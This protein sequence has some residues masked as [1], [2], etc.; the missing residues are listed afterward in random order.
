MSFS[1]AG[2]PRMK[3]GLWE[4][5][6]SRRLPATGLND[7]KDQWQ[8]RARPE[9][10]SLRPGLGARRAA[11]I[12]GY[13]PQAAQGPRRAAGTGE[14]KVSATPNTPDMASRVDKASRLQLCHGE[15]AL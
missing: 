1:L 13:W 2:L 9:S 6:H 14:C 8:D 10:H 5:C 4:P 11:L 7:S 15:P 12:Q 3:E